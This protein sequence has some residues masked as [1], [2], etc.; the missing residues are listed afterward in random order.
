MATKNAGQAAVVPDR[1]E[2]PAATRGRPKKGHAGDERARETRAQNTRS[3]LFDRVDEDQPYQRPTSLEA[4]AARPGMKQ[5]WIRV[6]IGQNIDEKNLARK[7]REGWRARPSDSVPKGFHAPRIRHGE[8]AGT[9]MVEGMLLM[10]MPM[11]LA[12]RREAM[13]RELTNQKTRAVNED[14]L[15]VNREAGGGFGPVKKGEKSVPV[16]E[17]GQAKQIELEE[18]AD[19]TS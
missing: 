1:I 17:V 10:E 2:K 3:E 18:E 7:M 9:V 11:K 4:P 15:R 14:L 12:K 19:L 16:R 5:R 8:F 13:I 6:G